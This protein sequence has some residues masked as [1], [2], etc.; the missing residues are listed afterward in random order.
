MCVLCC[1]CLCV[2]FLILV[3][4]HFYLPI[5]FLRERS[6][7]EWVGRCGGSGKR[8][9]RG[10]ND[11]NRLHDVS[12]KRKQKKNA[13]KKQNNKNVVLIVTNS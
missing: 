2:C 4:L 3:G 8:W 5:F 9:W 12:I 11:Q 6:G 10:N 7:V 13:M 1:S